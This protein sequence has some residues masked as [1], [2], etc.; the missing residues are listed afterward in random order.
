MIAT[1][2]IFL[3]IHVVLLIVVNFAT[4]GYVF[5]LFKVFLTIQPGHPPVF[6]PLPSGFLLW[7]VGIVFLGI[8]L[9]AAYSL[10]IT[11]TA[12]STRT[13]VAAIGDGFAVIL[14]NL[15]VFV[16]FYLTMC[17]AGFFCGLIIAVVIVLIGMLFGLISPILAAVVLVPIC[18]A[19]LLLL[20]AVMFGFNYYAWRGTLGDDPAA[21]VQQITA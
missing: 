19:M 17:L 4:G 1:A 21:V 9:S 10:A 12:L 11:Q 5:E 8:I 2:L 15:A 16:L 13:P 6:P 7:L 3:A 18:L 20:Y 14:R